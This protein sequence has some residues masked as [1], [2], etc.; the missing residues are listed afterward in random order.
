MNFDDAAGEPADVA[1]VFQVGAENN[2]REGTAHLIFAEVD[3]VNASGSCLHTQ[4][5]PCNAFIFADVLASFADGKTVGSVGGGG[6][7]KKK[8]GS[9]EL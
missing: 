8:N 6:E 3:E 4:D 5:F 1:H 7:Y 9:G 2:D